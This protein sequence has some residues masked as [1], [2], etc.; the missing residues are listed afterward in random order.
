MSGVAVEQRANVTTLRVNIIK[1]WSFARPG[2]KTEKFPH[3]DWQR[4][5][6][7]GR[8]GHRPSRTRSG[9]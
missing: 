9:G 8:L 5:A 2:L 1:G 3:E 6:A 7:G 4:P